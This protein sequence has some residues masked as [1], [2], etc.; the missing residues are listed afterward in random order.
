MTFQV[1]PSGH[2]VLKSS[3]M[4]IDGGIFIKH[5][6]MVVEEVYSDFEAL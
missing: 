1:I 3:R 6:R 2:L 5:I 4:R